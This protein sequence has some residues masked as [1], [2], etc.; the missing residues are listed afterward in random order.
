MFALPSMA[1]SRSSHNWSRLEATARG[2]DVP[3][4]VRDVVEDGEELTQVR[5]GEHRVE[6]TT[7]ALMH[8]AC[9]KCG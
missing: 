8:F 3:H 2:G 1:L 6:Q 5:R 7:L 4:L 9:Y